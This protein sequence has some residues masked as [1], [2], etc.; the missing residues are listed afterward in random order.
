MN[1]ALISQ[2]KNQEERVY[3]W[4]LYHF[5]E[6]FDTFVFFDDFSEDNTPNEIRRFEKD[7]GAI[8]KLYL[9]DE[10]GRNYTI[11]ESKNSETYG[12]DINL[13]RRIVRSY[14]KGNQIVKE[15]NPK[16][17]CAF[18]DVDEF[19]VTNH[20]KKVTDVIKEI[21]EEKKC[22]QLIVI[23]F[24]V[25]HN[26]NLEKQFIYKNEE[27][28]RWDFKDVEDHKVW[29]DRCKCIAMCETIND[30]YGVHE[31][32]KRDEFSFVFRDY[33]RLRMH[34]YRIPNLPNSQTISFVRDN[35]IKDKML[36]YQDNTL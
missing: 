35:T 20:D 33:N 36:T 27:Y 11:Q 34:H 3:D 17:I 12:F 9:T 22:T 2:I 7:H 29:R 15:T 1:N 31:I 16:A 8:V 23:N 25:L 32:N 26:Y 5:K 24:D 6:G 19:L 30:V 28:L 18:L 10:R 13:N 21:F 4:M 14:T